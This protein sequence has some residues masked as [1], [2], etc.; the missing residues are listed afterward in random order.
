MAS[1][2]ASRVADISFSNINMRLGT[3]TAN[4]IVDG[5]ALEEYDVVS[6]SPTKVTCWVASEEGKV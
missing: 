6:E 5:K 4:I 3:F 1:S 2:D